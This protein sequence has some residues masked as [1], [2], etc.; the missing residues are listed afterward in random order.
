MNTPY[1]HSILFQPRTST[2]RLF[3]CLLAICLPAAAHS[4]EYFVS[5]EGSDANDGKTPQ[6]PW[7]TVA[8]VNFQSFSPGDVIRFRRD[9]RWREQLIPASGSPQGYV[10]YSAYGS[11]EKPLLLGSISKS[12]PEDWAR[13][14]DNIWATFAVKLWWVGLR[15]QSKQDDWMKPRASPSVRAQNSPQ[16]AETG[17]NRSSSR[18]LEHPKSPHSQPQSNFRTDTS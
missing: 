8:R 6:T 5:R 14:D 7:R 17:R 15:K 3:L 18:P 2:F 9:D 10:T 13:Q 11:G 1:I 4:A 16:Q 12:R